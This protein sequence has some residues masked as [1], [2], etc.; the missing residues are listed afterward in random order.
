MIECDILPNLQA[1]YISRL[2]T[3][4]FSPSKIFSNLST[5]TLHRITTFFKTVNQRCQEF[6]EGYVMEQSDLY[7]DF[8]RAPQFT[9]VSQDDSTTTL[10]TNKSDS[11]K[12]FLPS[13]VSFQTQSQ[14]TSKDKVS[15]IQYKP[16]HKLY[17]GTLSSN[18]EMP[19]VPNCFWI[20]CEPI[21][22][23][24][25]VSSPLPPFSFTGSRLGALCGLR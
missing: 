12:T 23:E 14:K 1:R 7:S 17:Q 6:E 25:R 10:L 21:I 13:C 9:S 18:Q 5:S 22:G 8:S 16:N 24:G 19:A 20:C 15:T 2:C 3:I 11:Y 4:V